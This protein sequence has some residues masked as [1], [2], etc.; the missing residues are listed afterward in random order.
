MGDNNKLKSMIFEE[1]TKNEIRSM[2]SDKIDSLYSSRDFK[3][4]VK[5]IAGDVI[6]EL[7]RILWQQSNI[8]S[9]Q[10]KRV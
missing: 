7:F 1:L 3:K 4:A 8:Y 6:R 10:I 2:I 5:D 9:S